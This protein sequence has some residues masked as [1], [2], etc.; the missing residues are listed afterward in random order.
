MKKAGK[1]LAVFTT[2]LFAFSFVLAPT[3]KLKQEPSLSQFKVE[4]KNVHLPLLVFDKGQAVKLE[5]EN[6]RIFEGEKG[7]DGHIVWVEQVIQSFSRYEDQGIALAV[8]IDSS[9]SMVPSFNRNGYLED[10][11]LEQAKNAAR[12]LFRSVFREGKDVGMVSEIFYEEVNFLDS[13]ELEKVLDADTPGPRKR[14]FFFKN[15]YYSFITKKGEVTAAST[16]LFIDQNWTD[17]LRKIEVGIG[18]AQQAGGS[19]PLRDA[20]FNLSGH[21]SH[22]SGDLLRVAV[23]LTDGR[24]IPDPQNQGEIKINSR[25][26]AEV[27]SELQNRQ[28]LV[29]AI[30]LYQQPAAPWLLASGQA[31]ATD[32]LEA[33][34]KTTGGLAFFENDLTKLNNIFYQIG[35][36]IRNVNFLS[37]E[38]TSSKEGERF[39]KAETGEWDANKNWHKKKHTL[40][41]RQAYYYK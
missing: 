16:S 41:Y 5:K 19:T 37:Y 22:V 20:V 34:T 9:E 11:K 30:G 7:Q 39:I 24:D 40:F 38:P 4:V 23:V 10:N 6:F 15:S 17:S 3:L 27:V 31:Q 12:A 25:T 18:K 29:Y 28:V 32:F 21:F 13:K 26:L 36:M 33:L 2:C 35:S 8:A 1:F 14:G